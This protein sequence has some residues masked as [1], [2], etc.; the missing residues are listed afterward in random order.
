MEPISMTTGDPQEGV[1][2]VVKDAWRTDG[3]G[4][5]AG[6]IELNYMK[7][8][9]DGYRSTLGTLELTHDQVQDLEDFFVARHKARQQRIK[10][11]MI[12]NGI[13]E[14]VADIIMDNADDV[15]HSSSGSF[16]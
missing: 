12:D 7:A 3:S 16:G 14:A 5:R 11:T 6:F 9:G 1:R 2:I 13:D 4:Q 15:E 8:W 10:A